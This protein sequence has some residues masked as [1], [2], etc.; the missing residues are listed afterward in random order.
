MPRTIVT[1]GGYETTCQRDRTE[2][3]L[4]AV[5]HLSERG[6]PD[7]DVPASHRQAAAMFRCADGVEQCENCAYGQR[8]RVRKAITDTVPPGPCVYC[9]NPDGRTVDH[10]IPQSRSGPHQLANLVRACHICN[11]SKNN[12]TPSEWLETSRV[13]ASLAR[14][15]A[16][17]AIIGQMALPGV[18]G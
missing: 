2:R 10:V 13:Q 17:V 4:K 15:H 6:Y 1:I 8:R 3:W 9:G 5:A 16:K 12:L 18:D 14:Y 7:C 11:A